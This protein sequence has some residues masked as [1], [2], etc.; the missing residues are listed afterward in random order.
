MVES[1]WRCIFS[2]DQ[3]YTGGEPIAST[4]RIPISEYCT[5]TQTYAR[6]SQKCEGTSEERAR[7]PFWM[8]FK[9]YMTQHGGE[10]SLARNQILGIL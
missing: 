7:C 2:R 1:K 5:L 6:D 10:S 9:V 3:D 4:N 8:G